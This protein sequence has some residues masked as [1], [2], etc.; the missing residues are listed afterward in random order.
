[1]ERKGETCKEPRHKAE[2]RRILTLLNKAIVS[3]SLKDKNDVLNEVRK[4]WEPQNSDF[5]NLQRVLAVKNNELETLR[6]KLAS[7]TTARNT[8]QRNTAFAEDVDVLR[9]RHPKDDLIS[10]INQLETDITKHHPVQ[11]PTKLDEALA[12]ARA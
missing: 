8:L 9:R 5:E 1:M 12:E 7:E 6:S 4:V 2:A 10:V 11:F 3:T